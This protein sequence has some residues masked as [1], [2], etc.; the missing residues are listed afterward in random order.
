MS[1]RALL[2]LCGFILCLLGP[3]S[4]GAEEARPNRGQTPESSAI[5]HG[6]LALSL[7]DA[8]KMGLENNLN[9][10]VFRFQPLVAEQEEEIAWGSYDPEL[11]SE[12]GYSA[13]KTPNANILLGTTLSSNRSADGSG[14]FRGL[15]PWLSTQYE[16]KLDGSRATTNNTI[17]VL[18]P[19][20]RSNF[21]VSVTQPLLKDLVWN[22]AWTQ[23]KTTRILSE[24]AR[25]D[26]RNAVMDTVAAIEAAYWELIAADERRRVNEKSL[27]TAGALL[28]QTQIQY[29]VGVVAKVRITE[30]EAGL[31]SRDF[32][33]IVA[34]NEYGTAQDV[35]IDLVL[36]RGLRAESTLEIEPTDR[37]EDYI[38]YEIDV[39]AAVER[40]FSLRPDLAA[41]R[42]EIERQQ[43]QLKFAKS[44]RLPRLDA[45]VSYGYEGLAGDQN[46]RFNR[47]RFD[48]DPACDPNEQVDSTNFGDTFDDYFTSDVAD[49]FVARLQVSIPI[50]N[51]SARHGV[52]KAE[53]DLRRARTRTR[54]LEQ[55]IILDVR[56]KARNLESAQEGIGAAERR[57]VAAEEQLRA[58]EIRLEYG[59]STPFDVLLREEDLVE[60]ESEKIRAL[61]VYRT[62]T[63]ELHRAQGTILQN[64]NIRIDA[65]SAL[66]L[67]VR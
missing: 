53:L 48:P 5:L 33:M 13:T 54:R 17:S 58:E 39:P 16:L 10:E 9:V 24:S 20:L 19:E 36:G 32:N 25:Q 40:A 41:A 34:R 37:P 1:L 29:E 27:E 38:V 30:A 52:S 44:Q 2:P 18:S 51:T 56:Q 65:V 42:K 61:Q 63:T 23:V 3:F 31:A 12:F 59:E 4:A 49:Q 45:I 55:D 35:L 67:D 64:Q 6:K 60:A 50:P 15:V 7:A 26:F 14:G 8:V 46:S 43:I 28:D 11:F 22:Q 66:R 21:S 57:R 47:C 62:S